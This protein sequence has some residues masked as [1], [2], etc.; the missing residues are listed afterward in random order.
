MPRAQMNRDNGAVVTGLNEVR[1]CGRV[2][3]DA[4]E[5]VLPSGD[6]VVTWRVVVARESSPGVDTIDCAAW[7]AALRRRAVKLV[8]GHEVELSG[9]LRRRFWR[10]ASGAASR[11]EVEVA[12]LRRVS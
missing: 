12:S 8:D 4:V 5:R 2:S 7:S 6:S 1:L 3:G 10:G 11:Y 9:A